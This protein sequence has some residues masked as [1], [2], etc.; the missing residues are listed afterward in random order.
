MGRIRVLSD[1]VANQIA[2][3][4]VV[5]RPASVVKELLENALDA[6]AARIRVEVE[7]GG[8]KLI[9][10]GDDGCGMNRDD[11]LLAFERHATSKLR[12]AEDLLSIATLGFRGEALPSIA[13]VAR[14]TLETASGESAVGEPGTRIEIAGGK[15][16]HVD[17]AVL[18]HGTTI[19]V[20]DLFFN[21]PARRKFLRAESTELSHVTALVTHYALAHPDKHFELVSASHT[22]VSA[23]PVSR[24]A[25]RIYQIFGRDTLAALLPVAAELP[26]ERV[27]LPEPPPWK[28]D[29]EEAPREP[30]HLRLSGFYSKP[31]LQK[32]NRNSIYI[33]INKRLVRDRLLMHAITE[34]YRNV[35][36][37][38]SFPVAL[39]FL[40]LPAGEVDVNV[41]PAKT[42][43]RFRQ[44][45][46]IH[47][48]VR[49]SLRTALIKARPAAGFLAALD[50][51]PS[52]SP[53][54]MPP[55]AS[56]L[57]GSPDGAAP[58]PDS[59]PAGYQTASADAETFRLTPAPA[60]AVPGRLPFSPG[61]LG[62]STL[63]SR[64]A[65]AEAAAALLQPAGLSAALGC[66][67][68]NGLAEAYATSAPLAAA[69]IEAEQ[70]AGTLNQLGA[71]KAIGQLRESFILASGE[72]GLWI[73]DQH[74]AHERVLF[75][76]ILRDRNVEKVQRQRLLMPLLV[77]L[78]AYQ[79]V[80]FAQIA[81]ELEHNGFEVEPFGP[82][83]LA[84]K[85]APVGLE[86][87]GLE[88][89]LT[90]VIDQSSA[91]SQQ[92]EQ[93]EDLKVLR[94]RI[95]A[96]IAC[97]A[98]IKV[99]TRL[100]P[101]RMEWLLLELAKTE[102]PTSCPHGRPIA[103]LYSWREIQRAFHRI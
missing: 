9:R 48:F 58:L 60:P 42:E 88:R 16:L 11:A 72:D 66:S 96:S 13:S 59:E 4:E 56:P 69:Q 92:V 26:L 77:E 80:V 76:K 27:G 74:V 14:V 62:A 53:S 17:D 78:K 52:A 28:R 10:V 44:Q 2:A 83:T 23:P 100:D 32:L 39:L 73:I 20:A 38:T 75:E 93:N 54:L 40:E 86:G 24:T 1:Q 97:H 41:H 87:A 35:I 102:H 98:A 45:Q 15:I 63:G 37:P 103:L 50:S 99:N 34:A 101:V 94:S 71:L 18:P 82:Q 55:A 84:V 70:A 91:E 43:V 8:R 61:A 64:Q 33:F 21:T 81:E 51:A 65:W 36:P 22:L 57:P 49:D 7:A 89:M 67:A 46:V 5:D 31:E 25:E 85:A 12:T 47:D 6:G 30:G 19:S 3:G 90:E 79:M 29:P 68:N 95:A